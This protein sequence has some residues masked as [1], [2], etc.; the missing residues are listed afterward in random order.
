M[1]DP[2][3]FHPEPARLARLF[4]MVALAVL[5]LSA[6]VWVAVTITADVAAMAFLPAMFL[7]KLGMDIPVFGPVAR[8]RDK[9]VEV[10]EGLWIARVPLARLTGVEEIDH[11]QS[12]SIVGARVTRLRFIDQDGLPREFRIRGEPRSRDATLCEHLAPMIDPSRSRKDENGDRP[13]DEAPPIES[14]YHPILL[15]L[16]RRGWTTARF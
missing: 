12:G 8:I 10:R 14:R 6:I 9:S 2:I 16:H 4:V 1:S 5:I 13:L 11:H 15:P 7:L 3:D